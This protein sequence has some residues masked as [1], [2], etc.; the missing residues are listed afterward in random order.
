VQYTQGPPGSEVTEISMDAGISGTYPQ[1]MRFVNS[2]ERDQTFFVIRAMALAG[3]QSGLVNLRLRFPPGYAP[4]MPRQAGC[5]P[6]RRP[7]IRQRH[8]QDPPSPKRRASS[9]GLR[10]G[11]EDK[12]K[13]Y[14]LIAMI[15]VIIPV[16]AYEIHGYFA[17]PTTPVRPAAPPSVQL[18]NAAVAAGPSTPAGQ[19]AEKLTNAGIDPTLHF[20][21][22]AL[23][24]EV[25]YSGTGRN[26]FSAESAPEKIEAPIK[27]PRE[28]APSVTAAPAPPGPPRPQPSISNTSAMPGKGQV[29]QSLSDSR[30]DIFLARSGEIVDH[31]Y[32]VG[33]IMP[34]ASSDGPGLQQHA[35]P[36][37]DR[38]RR[39]RVVK[40]T[41]PGL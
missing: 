19:D 31:R 12:R 36:A 37:V 27:S 22:L 24:E 13:V 20:D 26:I 41:E 11:A 25:E 5:H 8:P 29:A 15:A 6:L 10:L 35:N 38:T 18:R 30:E 28:T 40:V 39:S 32:K 33:A 16:G 2:L 9:H 21:K 3:Q 4:Q 17:A 14:I 23:S 7:A 34:G 1:I